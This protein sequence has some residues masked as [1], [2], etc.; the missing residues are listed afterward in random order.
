MVAVR[1]W[2]LAPAELAV[3]I[4]Q[5]SPERGGLALS[6]ERG[7]IVRSYA[8]RGG[9]YVMTHDAAA[10]ILAVRGTTRVWESR[11]YQ[12]QGSFA[13][14]DWAPWRAAARDALGKGPAT[15]A[16]IWEHVRSD[17]ALAHLEV[18]ASGAGSDSLFK[19]L[20]WW[21]DICFGPDRDGS[22]TFR[23]LDGDPLWTGALD[24]EGAGPRAVRDYLAAYGPATPANLRY[25]LTEGL[26][27]PWRHVERWIAKLGQDVATVEMDG[28][29]ALVLTRD[30][31]SMS[32]FE[33]SEDIASSPSRGSTRLA[34]HR[35]SSSRRV[36]TVS[37]RASAAT[38]NCGSPEPQRSRAARR[39]LARPYDVG[40]KR[41]GSSHFPWR[42]RHGYQDTR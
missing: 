15:R 26:S 20:H 21:G 12:R 14:E 13:L 37:R 30:L 16:E 9:S 6:L 17:H 7:E 3:A 25:W 27:A 23:L 4:R 40:H 8:F 36:L 18:G 22:T 41:V 29:E 28:V 19:P 32:A 10:A 39:V 24:L 5:E 35:S 11:R 42:R 2:P 38:W 31:D 33:P 34:R 1:A